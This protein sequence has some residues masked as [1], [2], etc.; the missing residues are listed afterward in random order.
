MAYAVVR[1]DRL[2]GTDDRARLVSVRYNVTSTVEGQTVYTPTE[3]ENGSIV[4]LGDLE[5]GSREIYVGTAPAAN[6]ELADVVLIANPEVMYDERLRG[7]DKYINPAGKAIRGYRLH[8]HDIFSATAEAFDGTP[9]KGKIVEL[10][11]GT[12][13]KVVSSATN[14]ST[15][16]GKIIDVNVVGS[17]TYYVVEV[18]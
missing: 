17:Y 2:T 11:A 4:L 3:I 1:T 16:I 9:E 12:K 18:G 6:S 10:K 14:G 7:L 5:E 13:M 8:T 15:G